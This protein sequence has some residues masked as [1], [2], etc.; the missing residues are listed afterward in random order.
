MNFVEI[1]IFLFKFTFSFDTDYLF[2]KTHT[3]KGGGESINNTMNNL[4][5]SEK[6]ELFEGQ[7]WIM[8][9]FFKEFIEKYVYPVFTSIKEFFLSWIIIPFLFAA[10]SPAIPL[11]GVMSIMAAVMKYIIWHFRKL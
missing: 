7:N 4:E 6:S 8:D 11:I 1:I 9:N 5:D 2:N 10:V 3:M